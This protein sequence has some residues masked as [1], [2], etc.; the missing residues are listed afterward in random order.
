MQATHAR[1]PSDAG[2]PVFPI[3]S[4]S[5]EEASASKNTSPSSAS[6]DG[7]TSKTDINSK[8]D[9]NLNSGESANKKNPP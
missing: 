8:I 7:P 5:L 4:R 9:R 2:G 6:T 3:E 1:G